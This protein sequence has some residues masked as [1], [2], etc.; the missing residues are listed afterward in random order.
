MKIFRIAITGFDGVGGLQKR[1]VNPWSGKEG[2]PP[3]RWR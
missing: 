2:R 3:T 1:V